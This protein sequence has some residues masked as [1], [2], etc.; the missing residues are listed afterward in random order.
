MRKCIQV[1]LVPLLRPYQSPSC[2][3]VKTKALT[4]RIGCY[5]H[6]YVEAPNLCDLSIRDWLQLMA[7]VRCP[8]DW[9]VWQEGA[10]EEILDIYNEGLIEFLN[11]C[12]V[13]DT[14]LEIDTLVT[15]LNIEFLSTP[16]LGDVMFSLADQIRTTLSSL[17]NS[18]DILAYPFLGEGARR[19]RSVNSGGRMVYP[20][21]HD[22]TRIKRTVVSNGLSIYP[23]ILENHRRHRR[24]LGYSGNIDVHLL[25]VQRSTYDLNYQGG[26]TVN[27]ADAINDFLKQVVSKRFYPNLPDGV[28]LKTYFVCYDLHCQNQGQ[29]VDQP[30][31]TTPT[32]NPTIR[33]STTNTTT[34]S[35]TANT[36][37]QSSTANTATRSSTANTTTRTLRSAALS[38]KSSLS[39]LGVVIL[40]FIF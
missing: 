25:I 12:L 24:A 6:P 13:V 7:T 17:H 34:R 16:E 35:S 5:V 27:I 3:E 20:M 36:A 39:A 38:L 29:T 10:V 31:R 8:L 40:C 37:T 11:Y 23:S 28:Q 32:V 2:T 33:P 18:D 1:E 14:S 15:R 30:L 9:R 22:I 4:S 26:Q 21:E 19:K